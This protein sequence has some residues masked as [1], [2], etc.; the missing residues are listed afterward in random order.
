MHLVV[1]LDS[2]GKPKHGNG[3]PTCVYTTMQIR[4][5][6]IRYLTIRL[7]TTSM[8]IY[9]IAFS[10]LERPTGLEIIWTKGLSE[11]HD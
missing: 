4:T 10:K 5:H 3:L 1:F 8:F 6:P 9:S 7:H 2:Q 11:Q